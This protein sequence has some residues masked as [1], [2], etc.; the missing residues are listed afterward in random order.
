MFVIFK[1]KQADNIRHRHIR[2]LIA[3]GVTVPC[4]VCLHVHR[5]CLRLLL[6][7]NTI[8]LI[9]FHN[10]VWTSLFE[11]IGLLNKLFDASWLRY[12]FGVHL[13]LC[14]SQQHVSL[15]FFSYNLKNNEGSPKFSMTPA[16]F[17]LLKSTKKDV[18]EFFVSFWGNTAVVLY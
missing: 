13:N 11:L 18:I 14:L 17:H 5:S 15:L 3:S 4:Q 8:T 12:S 10:C 9:T 6:C 7:N 16:D 2:C 1:Q